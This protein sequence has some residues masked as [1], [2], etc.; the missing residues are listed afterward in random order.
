VALEHELDTLSDRDVVFDQQHPHR[1]ASD[2]PR[3]R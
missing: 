3:L 1:T 2:K